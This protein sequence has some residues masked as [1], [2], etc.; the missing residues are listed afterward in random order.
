MTSSFTCRH[1]CCVEPP[2]PHEHPPPDPPDCNNC[3]ALSKPVNE[4]QAKAERI[5]AR[6]TQK[7]TT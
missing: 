6:L 7:E 5:A 3:N 2:G 1:R 4:L